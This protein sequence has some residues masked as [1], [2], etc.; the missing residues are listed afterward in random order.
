MYVTSRI[1][2]LVW[3][4]VCLGCC[5][6][7]I[8]M[9]QDVLAEPTRTEIRKIEA[10]IRLPRGAVTLGQYVRYY[11]ASAEKAGVRQISG[12]YIARAWFKP[13][14]IP[15]TGIVVVA[16]EAEIP[17]PSDAECSVVFVNADPKSSA[18]VSAE[19]SGGVIRE[20]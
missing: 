18:N 5:L 2:S 19:C 12:I 16:G 14:A 4:V 15:A 11:Y 20:K 9:G 1:A 10:Q 7:S 13:S 8:A 3:I 17:V 6:C